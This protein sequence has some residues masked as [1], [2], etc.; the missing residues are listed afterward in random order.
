ML[1]P[2][3]SLFK[4]SK[5]PLLRSKEANE[6]YDYTFKKLYHA[7]LID[8]LPAIFKSRGLIPGRSKPAAQTWLGKYS[9]KAIYYFQEFPKHE[10]LN[11]YD[12]DT[13]EPWSVVL[14]F[15]NYI[16]D[17]EYVVPDE[18]TGFK[19]NETY[20]AIRQ[21]ETIAVG[22]IMPTSY[23]TAIYIINTKKAKEDIIQYIPKSMIS[24]LKFIN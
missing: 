3:K 19:E 18:D 2:Y 5:Y 15:S 10:I 14:E 17:A 21:K 4:E 9:G 1:T 8:T 6:P 24:K 11:S 16:I 12:P 20:K 23:L 7:T 13:G 22:Y